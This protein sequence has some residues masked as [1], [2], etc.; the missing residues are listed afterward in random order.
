MPQPGPRVLIVIPARGG[1]K[2]I[3]RKNLRSLHGRPLIAYAIDTAQASS[4]HPE[5]M[6]SSEDDEILSVAAALGATPHR[7]PTE[8]SSDDVALDRVV[9]DAARAHAERSG[10]PADIVVTMQPTSPLVRPET[11]DQAIA[12]L[13][14]DPRL[15]TVLTVTD[16]TH[17]RWTEQGDRFVPA[18]DARI[19]RQHLPRT[20]RETGGVFASRGSSMR[21]DDRIGRAVGVIVVE[22]AEAVDIDTFDDWA[23]CEWHLGHRD[24]LFVVTG[25]TDVGLG[26]AHNA[27]TVADALTRHRIRFLVDSTS[28]LAATTIAAR[29]HPVVIQTRDTLLDEIVALDPE[30]VVNDILDTSEAYVGA[31]K[32]AGLLVVNFEDLG[33]GARLA[34]L[35]I[36][37]IYPEQDRLPNHYFGHRYYCPRPEF[38]VTRSTPVREQVGRV[39]ITFGGTDPNDLTA[40]V[41]R[42]IGGV[43]RSR[44]IQ[45]HVILG[46]GYAHATSWAAESG[47]VVHR[48][49]ADMARRMAEA[50]V[51]FTSAGRT[52]FEI[53][54]VGTPAIVIAQNER[55]LSHLFATEDYGFI[56]LGLAS[57]VQGECITAT[58]E[59]LLDSR[60]ARAAMQRRMTAEALTGGLERVRLL[61]EEL[62]TT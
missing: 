30:V 46:M 51:I 15:D 17:L 14:S 13:W 29:H 36:N 60:E 7:R 55:E 3:P 9:W 6:V 52:T 8:F 32:A 2:G 1:S 53:A 59:Q 40:R 33:P 12:R 10:R 21:P 58:L 16:D 54:C 27:L 38:L 43:L 5:V 47:A 62:V 49:V 56:N 23:L 44:G 39:L 11:V 34:D 37:A 57:A 26:H 20:Y 19:N 28:Q 48:S 31:L 35:V 18:Y 42:A 22:G 50:D 41:A 61:I 45:L 25:N 4:F 24:V